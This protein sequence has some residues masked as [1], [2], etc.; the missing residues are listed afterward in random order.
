MS[1]HTEISQ[2]DAL[3]TISHEGGCDALRLVGDLM[4]RN[5]RST[6]WAF[7]QAYL[8]EKEDHEKTKEELLWVRS[9]LLL[10]HKRVSW[11]LGEGEQP[12]DLR[13]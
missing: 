9:R 8:G 1:E 13:D 12:E 4:A 2:G 11:L 3:V 10:T 7:E 5:T 6:E